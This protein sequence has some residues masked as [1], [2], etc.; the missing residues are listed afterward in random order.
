[1]NI[2]KKPNNNDHK[3]KM[4]KPSLWSLLAAKKTNHTLRYIIPMWWL[5][6]DLIQLTVKKD[7]LDIKLRDGHGPLTI[8]ATTRRVKTMVM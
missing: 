1:M 4:L 2:G 8:E 5:H 6:I 7:I 3:S